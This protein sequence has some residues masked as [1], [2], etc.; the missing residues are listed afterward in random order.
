MKR[1]ST[2]AVVLLLVV[3][4]ATAPIATVVEVKEYTYDGEFDPVVF[5]SWKVFKKH[6]C[7]GGHTHFFLENPDINSD[8]PLVETMNI[9][10]GGDV[11]T[12]IAYRYLKG[13]EK[14]IFILDMSRAHFTQVVPKLQDKSKGI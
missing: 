3:G 10:R 14:Y 4:C 5:F 13:G 12:L 8:V 1:L 7:D 6:R 11:Y 9:D 2:I